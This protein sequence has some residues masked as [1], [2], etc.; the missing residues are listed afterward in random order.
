MI[1]V[2]KYILRFYDY[3]LNKKRIV[4]FESDASPNS[5]KSSLKDQLDKQREL[6]NSLFNPVNYDEKVTV[7]GVEIVSMGFP[8]LIDKK[9]PKV[10]LFD[11]GNH[12]LI[13]GFILVVIFIS[14]N[15]E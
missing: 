12:D 10:G 11:L 9:N 3:F 13:A 4:F 6:K 5:L 2:N 7:A 15:V 8:K 14:L 1:I